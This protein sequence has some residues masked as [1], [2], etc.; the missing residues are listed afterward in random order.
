MAAEW[1]L[2]VEISDMIFDIVL[3]QPHKRHQMSAYATVSKHWQMMIERRL[4]RRI[5]LHQESIRV[6]GRLFS[7]DRRRALLKH[8]WLR[9][10]LPKYDAS[11]SLHAESLL[12][13]LRYD[14]ICHRAFKRL[15]RI[16]SS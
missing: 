8:L 10:E 16:L 1:P 9:I 7:H 11:D 14:R 6:F 4:F 5:I 13:L 3:E 12:E 2:P 15:L